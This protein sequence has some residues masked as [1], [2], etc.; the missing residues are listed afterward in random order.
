MLREELSVGYVKSAVGDND[1]RAGDHASAMCEVHAATQPTVMIPVQL[2]DAP[3]AA[4]SLPCLS[5]C[6]EPMLSVVSVRTEK[7]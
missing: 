2:L 7:S 6:S 5:Q 1:M 3:A 4:A